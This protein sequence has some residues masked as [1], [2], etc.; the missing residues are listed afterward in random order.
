MKNNAYKATTI[1]WGKSQADI[2]NLLQKNGISDTRFTVTA[3]CTICEFNYPQKQGIASVRISVPIPES[4]DTEKM[5]N[6]L[7][8]ALFYYLK[9]KFEALNFGLMEFMQEFLPY[10]VIKNSD[11]KSMT[12]YEAIAPQYK[13]SLITGQ[14]G[15]IA[16][17]PQGR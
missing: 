7:H 1:H 12:M 5:K 3:T 17:L 2:C 15:A 9:T 6:Q 13:E 11:G 8:R 16:M 14:Q 10:L 4:R